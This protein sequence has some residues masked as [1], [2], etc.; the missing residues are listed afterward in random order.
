VFAKNRNYCGSV[1]RMEGKGVANG[2]RFVRQWRSSRPL[3]F[4]RY[5]P[6]SEMR[7]YIALHLHASIASLPDLHVA[8]GGRGRS[9]YRDMQ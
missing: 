8:L 9:R 2:W 4:M 5:Q 7:R 6:R 1:G 3:L